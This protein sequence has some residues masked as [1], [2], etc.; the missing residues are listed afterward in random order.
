METKPLIYGLIGF[1]IGGLMVSIAATLQG[2][3]THTNEVS[4]SQMT[5][6]LRDKKGDE[7]DKAFI[8]HMIAHHEAAVEMSQLS[9]DRATHQELKKLSVDIVSAQQKEIAQMKQW[10]KDWGYMSNGSTSNHMSH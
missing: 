4:M 8:S 1:F 9:A 7:Y 10:Q 2:D 3:A 6:E 5:E